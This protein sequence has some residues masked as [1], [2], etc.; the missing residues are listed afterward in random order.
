MP[1]AFLSIKFPLTIGLFYSIFLYVLV[2][3]YDFWKIF[4]LLRAGEG[5]IRLYLSFLREAWYNEKK[6]L[7]RR[8]SG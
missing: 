5:K 6:P 2:L 1:S 3:F 8:N 7:D 4:L